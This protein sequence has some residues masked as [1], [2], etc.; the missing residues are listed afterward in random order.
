M[1]NFR[2]AADDIEAERAPEGERRRVG[3]AV[4]DVTP[5]ACRFDGIG[6]QKGRGRIGRGAVS[7]TLLFSRP[8]PPE[9]QRAIEAAA[10]ISRA[11]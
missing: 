1:P 3:N 8:V 9:V 2:L 7:V 6:R 11:R 10:P 5:A 4:S